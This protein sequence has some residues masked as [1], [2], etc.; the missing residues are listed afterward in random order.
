M[1]ATSKAKTSS[2]SKSTGKSSKSSGKKKVYDP[3]D[4]YD[5]KSAQDFADD[6][7]EEFFSWK[8]NVIL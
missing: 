2:S 5:Y 6:K 4:V 7:Y 1:M 8:T 3:Y